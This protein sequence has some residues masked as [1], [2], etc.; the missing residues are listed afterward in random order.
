MSKIVEL[1]LAQTKAIV[2]G[3]SVNATLVVQKIP[4]STVHLPPVSLPMGQNAPPK[5]V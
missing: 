1:N 5:R 2:G 4:T 3:V